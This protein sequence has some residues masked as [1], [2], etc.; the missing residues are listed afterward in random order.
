MS[1]Q[2]RVEWGV[3]HSQGI[4]TEFSEQSARKWQLQ[5][6]AEWDARTNSRGIRPVVVSRTV[7]EW[8]DTPDPTPPTVAGKRGDDE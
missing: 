3:R 4:R 1:G 2:A 8:A 5:R 7:T 6:A